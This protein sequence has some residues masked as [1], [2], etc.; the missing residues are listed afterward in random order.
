MDIVLLVLAL[1]YVAAALVGLVA[2]WDFARSF[3]REPTWKDWL[4]SLPA[5]LFWPLILLYVFLVVP[6]FRR[7]NHEDR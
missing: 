4:L 6:R 1:L 3:G 2:F 5:S 7:G